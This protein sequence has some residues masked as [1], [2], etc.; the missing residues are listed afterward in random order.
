MWWLDEGKMDKGASDVDLIRSEWNG[1][2]IQRVSMGNY[3]W[4]SWNGS[5]GKEIVGDSLRETKQQWW[6]NLLYRDCSILAKI[7]R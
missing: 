3:W 7:A 6:G 1:G 2:S 4:E 5:G